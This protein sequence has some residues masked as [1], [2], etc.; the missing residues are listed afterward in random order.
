MIPQF[1]EIRL[2]A[3]REL[4]SGAVMRTKEL[5]DPLAKYFQLTEDEIN[6]WYPSGNGNIFLDRISWALSYLFIAGLVEKPKRGDYKI[7]LKGL[8]MLSNST[9]E[10]ITIY[11][12][13][14]VLANSSKKIVKSKG[15]DPM[16]NKS[17]SEEHTPQENLDNS[18]NNIKKSISSEILATILSKKPY[19]FERLVV[20]LL[21]MMGY[22][23]EVKN[24]CI[25]TKLTNDGGIDGIIKEDILGFNHI[26]IQAKRYA[27]HSNVGRKEIQSFVGAVAGTSSKKGVFITTSDYTKEAIDYVESLNGSPTI[28]LINGLQLTEY[29]YDCGLGLQTEKVLKVMKMDMDYWDSM[30]DDL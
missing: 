24:S 28:I 4:S 25:V 1:E 29:M 10:Q 8:E 27:E 11:V 22:G 14:A 26:S 19:E 15:C 21:Q 30:D 17:V 9:D 16:A 23:G 13:N 12:K 3:L 20:K 5:R 6:A 7:S 18:Y 2:Q